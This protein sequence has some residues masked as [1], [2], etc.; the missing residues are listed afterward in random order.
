M[1]R[2]DGFVDLKFASSDASKTAGEA[3]DNLN[4]LMIFCEI[5]HDRE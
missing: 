2:F 1:S 5:A 3:L 4:C